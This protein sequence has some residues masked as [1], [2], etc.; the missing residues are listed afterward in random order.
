MNCPKC[1]FRTRVRE[2]RNCD[3]KTGL[4][5]HSAAGK[6]HAAVAWYTSD[7]LARKR[8]CTNMVCSLRFVTVELTLDDLY[9]GWSPKD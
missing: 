9:D 4:S 2:T 7:W 8:V 1:G 6:V 3:T 5:P